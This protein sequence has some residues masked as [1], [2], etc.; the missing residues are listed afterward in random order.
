MKRGIAYAAAWV[1][2]LGLL[3]SSCGGERPAP[4]TQ[5]PS[6]S[7]TLLET[8]S[9]LEEGETLMTVDGREV[10]AWR[11][12][13]W[14]AY[15]CDHLAQRYREEGLPLDWSAPV[16]DGT[17]ADYAKEQ[18]LTDT[19]LYAVVENWA[20]AY[21]PESQETPETAPD[22]SAL[23]DLGL[24]ET[25]LRELAAVG[26]RYNALWE[27][28]RAGS[29]PLSPAEE[30]LEAYG[31]EQGALTVDCILIRAGEDRSAAGERAAELFS[32][33][34]GAEDQAARFQELAA[35]EDG[36]QG[37]RTC[38]PG[39][40]TL[41]ETLLAAA[42]ALE[43]GQCSGILEAPEGYAILRRLPLDAKALLEP[44][45]DSRL[46]HSAREARIT[47]SE[48]YTA[49]DAAAFYAAFQQLRQGGSRA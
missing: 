2:V 26:A 49:L 14:L 40:G 3:L 22:A 48:S 45:F 9:G 27:L 17:L 8:A 29:S 46:E 41:D 47:V 13:Y 31:R 19:A 15:T 18:A 38:L 7:A 35:A 16:E 11:C 21:L 23:P 36:H 44:W 12:L 5:P 34:N 25:Q 33:L 43:E 24:S 10:P 20:Q 28:C 4:E 6:R 30:D 32:R 1:L 39:D 42:E 37:P